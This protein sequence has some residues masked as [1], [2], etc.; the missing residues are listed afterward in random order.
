MRQITLNL[1]LRYRLSLKVAKQ[2]VA[3]HGE[4]PLFPRISHF[5]NI[6]EGNKFSR[7][8][9]HV[10]AHKNIKRFLGSNLAIVAIA[11]TMLPAQ[12]A[13]Y[14]EVSAQ[15]DVII[16]QGEPSLKT[17]AYI[18]FPLLTRKINQGYFFF[19]PGV[20]LDGET[21]DPIYPVMVGRV[22]AVQHS[23][24]AYGNA[25]IIAHQDGFESLYAHMSKIEVNEGD[26]VTLD[27]KIG[28][29]GSTG[30]STGSHLHLEI[31]E[32]GRAL[33]PLTILPKH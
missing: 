17:E 13:L 2:R 33:N 22:K 19:H 14:T 29:V 4:L 31:R 6:K 26:F 5:K 1:P 8:L 3:E 12:P 11:T 20:D 15:E 7:Y 23:N 10:F 27:T 30:H 21:G 24:Y 25:V 16:E 32:N 18:R 28:E 9:R